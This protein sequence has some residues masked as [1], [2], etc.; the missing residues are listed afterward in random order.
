MRVEKKGKWTSAGIYHNLRFFSQLDVTSRKSTSRLTE[1]STVRATIATL[2]AQSSAVIMVARLPKPGWHHSLWLAWRLELRNHKKYRLTWE[3]PVS[4]W[5]EVSCT[6]GK[7]W[8][9]KQSATAVAVSSEH[10]FSREFDQVTR[11]WNGP[12]LR[13]DFKAIAHLIFFYWL[14]G[15]KLLNNLVRLKH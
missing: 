13:T 2:L 10:P 12:L 4:I 5:P 6:S 14:L 8:K 15:K 3:N 11:K 7:I 1:P 9:R